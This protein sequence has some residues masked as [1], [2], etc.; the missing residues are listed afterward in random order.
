MSPAAARPPVDPAFEPLFALVHAPGVKTMSE[1]TPDE[2]RTMFKMLTV[3]SPVDGVRTEDRSV[4]GPA[5]EV[6][7]RIVTPESDD[8][9]TG[10]LVWFH[11]GGFV[12]GDLDTADDTARRLAL[13]AGCVVVSVDYRLAPEHPAPAAVDDC[14][15]A[16]VWVAENLATLGVAGGKFAVGG[17]SAGGNLA[18]VIAQRDALHGGLGVAAQ[19]LVYPVTDLAGRTE[20]YVA[21]GEGYFLTVDAMEWF[22]ANYLGDLDPADPVASPLRSPDAVLANVCPAIVHVAG[23]DPLHDEGVAYAERLRE[24]GVDVDLHDFETMIHGFYGM[25]TITPVAEEAIQ[26]AGA[27]LRRLLSGEG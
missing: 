4:P 18:A 10:V 17:D 23:Y 3:Q 20:S 19:L 2:A 25:P 16:T 22:S 5:G 11:G 6:P 8:E 1:M 7:V 14:W 15:A 27:A 24:A 13:A 9:P 26:E 21:N 12:I